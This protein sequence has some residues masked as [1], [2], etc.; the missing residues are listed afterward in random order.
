[1]LRDLAAQLLGHPPRATDLPRL[2]RE[3]TDPVRDLL[4]GLPQPV[5]DTLLTRLCRM[6]PPKDPPDQPHPADPAVAAGVVTGLLLDR[7][8]HETR[9]ATAT[10]RDLHD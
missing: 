7:L 4:P 10:A 6:P 2:R 1:M 9:S 8:G 3:V 5:L